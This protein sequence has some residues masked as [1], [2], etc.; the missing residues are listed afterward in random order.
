MSTT[1]YYNLPKPDDSL[2]DKQS[3][4]DAVVAVI[5]ALDM[6]DG[7]LK[8]NADTVAT[9]AADDHGHLID[10]IDGLVA[11]LEGKMPANA[12]FTLAGLTDA[13]LPSEVPAGYILGF[14]SGKWQAVS[15]ASAIGTHGHLMSEIT[16]LVAALN[17]LDAAIAANQAAI[18]T[19]VPAG[20]VSAFARNT[21]PDGWLKA[22]GAAVSRTAYAALYS[23]IGTTFGAGDGSTTF[24]LPDLRGEFVRGWD[25]S[26]GVDSGRAFGSSQA[27]QNKQHSHTGTAQSDGAHIHGASTDSVGAHN[28]GGG[29]RGD[30]VTAGRYGNYT[31]GAGSYRIQLVAT[32]LGGQPATSTDGNHS[33]GVTVNSGGAHTHPLS[34]A[35]DGGNE[36]R[37]RNVALLHCIKY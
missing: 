31:S 36:A 12:T 6:I 18:A 27:D 13:E 17:D 37:P 2:E 1:E 11:A 5:T 29:Y 19:A 14:I 28:H 15:A 10:E 23:A 22:N 16:G 7:L 25:D 26:R 32:Q 30:S 4:A 33:H 9:K 20:A 8:I 21:A 3:L 34:I 24:N 35:N